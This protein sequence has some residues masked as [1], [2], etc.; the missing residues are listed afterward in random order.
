MR[1]LEFAESKEY[2]N[3]KRLEAENE[4]LRAEMARMVPEENLSAAENDAD[5]WHGKWEESQQEVARLRE[6]PDVLT[7]DLA[8]HGPS[9]AD[10]GGLPNVV[11]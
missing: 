7:R 5:F 3:A 8:R 6:E 9:T 11:G 1:L 2:A 4:R 10:G